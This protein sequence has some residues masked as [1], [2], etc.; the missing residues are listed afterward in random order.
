MIG[1][2]GI[3]LSLGLLIYLAYRGWSII[4]LAPILALLASAFAIFEGGDFHGL[5]IYT[6]AFM[7]SLG[8][9]V[10][11]YFP[12]FMLGA[13]FGKLMDASGSADAIATFISEKAGKGKELWAIVLACAVITYGGVSLFV[14]AFAIYPIGAALFRQAGIPK[15]ILPPAI[16]LGAFTFTMTAIPGTPQIQNAIPMQYFGTDGF[17]APILGIIAAAIMLFGGML[18]L[19]WRKN[20]AMAAGEGYGEHKEEKL[21]IMDRE[22]LPPF[23][24]AIAPIILVIASNYIFSKFIFQDMDASYLE[25]YGTTLSKV[26]GDWSLIVSLI[27]GVLVA[28]ICN[29][30]RMGS[31]VE[32][33]KEG[34]AGSFL[35]IM[36][37]ASEVG[38]G[39]VIKTL[40]GFTIL[41]NVMLNTFE[42]PLIGEAISSSVLAGITGSASGGLSI[43]LETFA[44]TF[45][46]RAGEAGISPEVLHRV[47]SVA[48]GGMDT[49]PHNGAVITLLA[50][51]GMSHKQCYL[52][53]GMCTVIIPLISCAV[54]IALGSIGIV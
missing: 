13:I 9:Y 36:N 6:E 48:C 40:A 51:T 20:K 50:V 35:A 27:I 46:E 7:T 44:P 19:T 47:A 38:Y 21:T 12:I 54:I 18:W 33:L 53:I 25:Q 29:Y 1:V 43:A 8:N 10:K 2:I 37:T 32:V 4:L 5:A 24:I 52:N 49:L 31:V 42:N 30:K 11:A 26:I 28:I 22:K 39:N 14:A 3:I 23:G 41:A 45:L 16:A 17:A 34:V 15:R